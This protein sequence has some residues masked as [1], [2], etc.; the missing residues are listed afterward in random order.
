MHVITIMSIEIQRGEGLGSGYKWLA[1]LVSRVYKAG[2][3][4]RV[5]R[6]V[7][8]LRDKTIWEDGSMKQNNM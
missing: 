1:G 2:L 4:C 5:C 7:Q 6:G 3:V 8:I